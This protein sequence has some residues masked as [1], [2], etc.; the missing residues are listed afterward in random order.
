MGKATWL[1]T[2]V[3]YF[4]SNI[5]EESYIVLVVHF[6]WKLTNK[7][8]PN[9][10]WLSEQATFLAG[11]SDPSSLIPTHLSFS[12]VDW[13][14]TNR[15]PSSTSW[16]F[17]SGPTWAP[18]SCRSRNHL[19]FDTTRYKMSEMISVFQE[20]QRLGNAIAAYHM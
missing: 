13:R 18:S 20:I 19:N 1:S 6:N 4:V 8:T 5:C 3:R 17:A 9:L 15:S 12:K 2:N 10:A 14:A 7:R 16:S 11:R